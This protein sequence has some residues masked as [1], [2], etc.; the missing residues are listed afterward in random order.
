M[1]QTKNVLKRMMRLTLLVSV[2]FAALLSLAQTDAALAATAPDLLS[3][4][5]YGI[6]S[7]TFTNT[8]AGSTINGDVC[9]TT[10][11]AVVPTITGATVVPCPASTGTDQAN[12]RAVLIG[13]PCTPLGAAVALN[14]VSIGGGTPGTFPPGCYSS[15]GAM[16]ITTGTTVTLSGA[17]VYIFR[18]GGALNPAANSNV[19]AVGGACATDV[20][21]A[22]LG[23]TTIGA[24]SSFVG[25][26]LA[27]AAD[28]TIGSTV[29]FQG[30]ALAFGQT[31]TIDT[32]TIT[33]PICAP[34]VP[35]TLLGKA[36]SPATINA[37]AGN[38]STLTITLSNP[39]ATAATLTAPL[40]D[41]LPAGVTIAAAP[42]GSTT[43]GGVVSTG[44]NTVTLTGGSIPAD[45][46]CTVRV[47]VT[48][49]IAGNYINQLAAGALQTSNG[50]NV[51]P[52]FATLT[53]NPLVPPGGAPTLGKAFSP[54]LINVG[55]VSTLT[56][57]LSNPNAAV[58]TLTAPFIDNLPTGVVIATTPNASTTC[59]GTGA[60]SA[61]P[62]GS[63]VTLPVTRSIPA[64]GGGIAGTCTVTVDVT[65]LTAGAHIN[66]LA[67]GALVTDQGTNA[68]PA[69]ATLTANPTLARASIP[70]LSEWGM[71]IFMVLVGLMSI[72][73]LRR[74]KAKA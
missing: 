73:Y 24:N 28:I 41:T 21:W 36:F 22:P 43:C 58:A 14:T 10:G 33:V 65:A 3:D 54:V 47:D 66:S 74:Q 17:G 71:I 45:G 63:T 48:A 30:R 1:S 26:V 32:D 60:V 29:I 53:V 35:T 8:A 72:Y 16:N 4:S 64:S 61:I 70:T 56:I 52:A 34:F 67:A 20:F 9:Y 2:G 59:S 37:G 50:T 25:N 27:P 49:P 19:V 69:V 18:P 39:N 62:G 55:G 7:S 42:L 31:V 40:T 38:V 44:V 12:A 6:V 51:A 46:T 68:A 57:T 15:T 11:P 5:T 13:Q 23:A